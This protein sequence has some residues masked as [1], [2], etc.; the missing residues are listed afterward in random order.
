[1]GNWNISIRGLGPHH[2]KDFPNDADRL[3]ARFV[4]ELLSAGHVVVSAEITHG[5]ATDLVPE[6]AP[7]PSFV[8]P[9]ATP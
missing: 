9:K 6:G 4:R 7:P 5:G 2:N 3:A 8:L 1:M